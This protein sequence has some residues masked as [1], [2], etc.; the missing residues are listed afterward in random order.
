MECVT[1]A[2]TEAAYSGGGLYVYNYG[3]GYSTSVSKLKITNTK[4]GWQGGGAYLYTNGLLDLEDVTTE[5]TEAAYNGGGLYVSNTSASSTSVSGLT[6]KRAKAT[7]TYASGGGAY[8]LVYGPLN[9]QRSLNMECVT[10]ANTE[11]AYSGGGLYVYNYGSGSSTSV[12]DLRISNTNTT[13]VDTGYGGGAHI[14]ANGPLTIDDAVVNNTSTART[15]GGLYVQNYGSG[16]STSV[17]DLKISNTKTTRVNDGYGGGLY[18]NGDNLNISGYIS[19]GTS[20]AMDGGSLYIYLGED[21][22]ASINGAEIK[23]S[24]AVNSRNDTIVCGGGGIFIEGGSSA[25]RPRAEFSG[26]SFSNV[27]AGGTGAYTTGGAVFCDQYIRLTMSDCSINGANG[28]RGGAIGGYGAASCELTRVS[29]A[30]CSA[31]T[32]GHILYGDQYAETPGIGITYTVRPGC[33]VDGASINAE[34]WF[35]FLSKVHLINSSTITAGGF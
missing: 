1:I 15:G 12:S 27:T 11:A 9:I 6:V 18:L 30:N 26:I 24:A 21:G 33:T 7:G 29:F 23:N 3:S 19:D 16:Y 8:I 25:S 32:Y 22:A 31:V 10:I 28:K 5:D 2:N 34:T 14:Y 13:S 17:S 4:S 20:S 35:S